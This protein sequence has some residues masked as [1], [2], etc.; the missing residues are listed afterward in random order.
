MESDIL[1]MSVIAGEIFFCFVFL[2]LLDTS[3]YIY[4]VLFLN[5]QY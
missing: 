3:L 1:C 2:A 5:N 4:F